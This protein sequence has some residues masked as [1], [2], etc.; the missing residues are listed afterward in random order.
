MSIK[1]LL[2]L[3]H[4]P[5][6]NFA[7]LARSLSAAHCLTERIDVAVIG[8]QCSQSVSD[9]AVYAMISRVFILDHVHLSHHLAEPCA[10]VLQPMIQDYS[11]VLFIAN[12]TSKNVMARLAA[13]CDISPISD[14]IAI[15]SFTQF[16]RPIYAGNL[17]ETVESHQQNRLISIRESVFAPMAQT[18]PNEPELTHVELT[19][20]DPVVIFEKESITQQDRPDL[21]SAQIVVSGGRGLGSH[22]NFELIY[23]LA[24]CLEAGV[25]AS[26]AAVDAGYV[27][28][29]FQVG[30][31]G[32]IVAPDIYIAV[33]I[34][35]AIQHM[36]GMKDSRIIIAINQDIEAPMMQQCDYGLVADLF[37]VVPIMIK[38]FTKAI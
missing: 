26:R 1:V 24:D 22:E 29:D 2:V 27:S 33:G 18:E 34:S 30:Q 20:A 10:Q 5:G 28:N 12:T 21:S 14:V 13:I 31:T 9:L 35:G 6:Q 25:G 11:H 16:Q 7:S 38:H 3:F 32:K 4:V 15:D 8:H 17:I 19:L 37:E 23:D 36:A